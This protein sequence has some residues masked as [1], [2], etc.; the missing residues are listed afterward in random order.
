MSIPLNDLLHATLKDLHTLHGYP[1]GGD[2]SI[3]QSTL[4]STIHNITHLLGYNSNGFPLNFSVSHHDIGT[5]SVSYQVKPLAAEITSSNIFNLIKTYNSKDLSVLHQIIEIL[6]NLNDKK[7]TR[8]K[9]SY[10]FI[11]ERFSL[12]VE[13]FIKFH[14]ESETRLMNYLMKCINYELAFYSKIQRRLESDIYLN[15]EDTQFLVN[16]L[17]SFIENTETVK[18]ESDE[19]DDSIFSYNAHLNEDLPLNFHCNQPSFEKIY[20]LILKLLSFKSV[21]S[22]NLKVYTKLIIELFKKHNG[23]EFLEL[24][25][26]RYNE[27]KMNYFI[28]FFLGDKSLEPILPIH[29]NTVNEKILRD[30]KLFPDNKQEKFTIFQDESKPSVA[31]KHPYSKQEQES[32]LMNLKHIIPLLNDFDLNFDLQFIHLFKYY[33]HNLYEELPIY[34][35]PQDV[36]YI[37]EIYLLI[38]T[39]VDFENDDESTS[40]NIKEVVMRLHELHKQMG[41]NSATLLMRISTYEYYR[42]YDFKRST[43]TKWRERSDRIKTVHSLYDLKWSYQHQQRFMTHYLQIWFTKVQKYQKLEI[44]TSKFNQKTI[45]DKYLTIWNAKAVSYEQYEEKALNHTIKKYLNIWKTESGKKAI[46]ENRAILHDGRTQL[47]K[48]YNL[49]SAKF[50]SIIS[51]YS[52]SQE[53]RHEF[54][55]NHD[56]K[57]LLSTWKLWQNQ[58]NLRNG[59]DINYKLK[60][61]ARR[62]TFLIDSKYFEKWSSKYNLTKIHDK[63]RDSSN[64]F[65]L[66]H[67]Y[68]HWLKKTKLHTNLRTALTKRDLNLKSD[69]FNLW[70][71]QKHNNEFADNY[72]RNLAVMKLF[73]LW[74]LHSRFKA[75]TNTLRDQL[76]LTK[77]WKLWLLKYQG[78]TYK[79]NMDV[80]FLKEAF[81]VWKQKRDA[82]QGLQN[83]TSINNHKILDRYMTLWI[84][85]MTKVKQ[86]EHESDKV[87]QQKHFS[88]ILAKY[89]AYNDK[90]PSNNVNDRITLQFFLTKWKARHESH[91]ESI[92][93]E[94]LA[95]FEYRKKPR[96][97]TVH[98]HK[99][100]SVYNYT[101]LKEDM[102]N[103]RCNTFINSSSLK[104]VSLAKWR[105]LCNKQAELM[106]KADT[107]QVMLLLK[108][109]LI[110]WYEKYYSKNIYLQ[111]V[112]DDYI[113]R[114]DFGRLQDLLRVWFM[115][116]IKINKRNQ[117]S[118]DIFKERWQNVK[119]KSILELWR[120]K[121]QQRNVDGDSFEEANT[122]MISNLSPLANK[123]GR[124]TDDSK[125]YLH[126]PLKQQVGRPFMTP[127][128]STSPSKLQETTERMKYERI[129][130]L[131]RH[132][133]KAKGTSTPRHEKPFIRLPPPKSYTNVLPPKPPNFEAHRE[134][135]I[136]HTQEHDE[137]NQRLNERLNTRLNERHSF[138][139]FSS[140][141]SNSGTEIL[142]RSSRTSDDESIIA[143]AKQLRRITPIVFPSDIEG[144]TF[145]PASKIRERLRASS[146]EDI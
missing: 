19:S 21:G 89:H 93:N 49:F 129:D 59:L 124:F 67:I 121:L 88:K 136:E 101:K 142:S 127:A 66:K 32:M 40:N 87:V 54:Q 25:N 107:F 82:L 22:D 60:E 20:Y 146:I 46:L 106:E 37:D 102:L 143:T 132:F 90:I 123:S 130:A 39:I 8:I 33:V 62:E 78:S 43:M 5:F 134:R 56:T 44:E 116:Y 74:K 126:T 112:L 58:I 65:L 118:C 47:R 48:H 11:V 45:S 120:F 61:L 91:M 79:S 73:K 115:K 108:K 77:G 85:R 7:P 1:P 4:Q 57:L 6:S 28:N 35:T 38:K 72:Y 71:E 53:I 144:P 18:R 105:L 98:F 24:N 17:D 31:S 80:Y 125:S 26:Y 52:A 51:K 23:S 117:Q 70:Y 10:S 104:L 110:I 3:Y 94:R 34:S 137:H 109:F 68:D 81:I 83:Q 138:T 41:T 92:Y 100:I 122:S 63:V 15:E 140:A 86:L 69:I 103:L 9:D 111:Q 96:V 95:E 113:D 36:S 76:D 42:N 139:R 2:P 12:L 114:K 14:H 97:L 29:W 133:G 145:S 55:R 119:T 64:T 84:S 75:P 128:K 16:Y 27:M 131:R 135:V 141:T 99:W 50:N 30:I 13:F